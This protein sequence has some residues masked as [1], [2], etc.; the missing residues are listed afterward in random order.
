M[1]QRIF[2][3][4]DR[5]G[6][7]DDENHGV[8]DDAGSYNPIQRGQQNQ[9]A[10]QDAQNTIGN[11]DDVLNEPSE[12]PA[13]PG[14]QAANKEDLAQQENAGADGSNPSGA[15][16]AEEA[17]ARTRS[18][19]GYGGSKGQSST[20]Q[21]EETE[22]SSDN[23]PQKVMNFRGWIKKGRNKAITGGIITTMVGGGLFFTG[24]LIQTAEI[25]HAGQ[26]LSRSMAKGDHDSA[27]RLK[28]LFKSYRKYYRSA[29]KGTLAETRV[30]ELGSRSFEKTYSKLSDMGIEMKPDS[31]GRF[32]EVTFDRTKM[33]VKYP[34]LKNMSEAE[35]KDFVANK[36]RGISPGEITGTGN[37]FKLSMTD[38]T[39]SVSRM[40][41]D[42]TIGFLDTGKISQAMKARVAK[43]YLGKPGL[44]HP[45]EQKK[46]SLIDKAVSGVQLTEEEQKQETAREKALVETETATITAE[47]DKVKTAKEKY[48]SVLAKTLLFTALVCLVRDAADSIAAINDAEAQI[49]EARAFDVI[50][51]GSQDQ[52]GADVTLAQTA[53]L[54]HS[55]V[56][57]DG[58]D[59][60]GGKALNSLS[61]N[62][63]DTSGTD[64]D[65]DYKVAFMPNTTA[66]TFKTQVSNAVGGDTVA[67]ILCS[68]AGIVA[69]TIAGLALSFGSLVAEVG[70][71]GTLTGPIVAFWAL[72]EGI[73]FGATS[74]VIGYIEHKIIESSAAKEFAIDA[75]KGV[76]GGN[77]LAYG[78]RYGANQVAMASGGVSLGNN[79]STLNVA[80]AEQEDRMDFQQKSVFARVFDINDYQSLTGQMADAISPSM[81][82]NLSNLSRNALDIPGMF[83]SIFG[84][85]LPKAHAAPAPYDWGFPQI[86][87]PESLLNDPNL[88]DGF[89]NAA[90]MG[91]ILDGPAGQGLR[92]KAK[93][94]FG[95]TISKAA[96]GKW[97]AIPGTRINPN[98]EAYINAHCD[99]LSDPNWKRTII[100]TTDIADMKTV[101]CYEGND[102]SCKDITGESSINGGSATSSPTGP[103]ADAFA[104]SD[105]MTCSVGT[106]GGVQ[107][108]YHNGNLIKI[109]ICIVQGIQ[110]NARIASNVD[111]L[112]N[113]AKSQG[114]PMSGGGFRT[115]AGQIDARKRNNCPD[116][117]LSPASSCSPPTALPGYSNHQMGLAID[118][119]QNGGIISSSSSGFS[120]L[121]ANASKYGLQNLPSEPWHWSVDGN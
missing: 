63:Q 42:D 33:E 72:K 59:M 11:I 104:P 90:Q 9:A 97:D 3:Q 121:K 20:D 14:S 2:K 56:D 117:N 112:L 16:T 67:A 35:F 17:A 75:F 102:Q 81:S 26:I 12:P 64:I 4:P 109:R 83:G 93:A 76:G 71:A 37:K 38:R 28:D 48:G 89:D 110:V 80:D 23:G 79:T 95:S 51:T 94:C 47:T 69:Q 111:S 68:P 29:K 78:A 58:K 24:P 8:Y 36:I 18:A 107:D 86:G 60:W 19:E 15:S 61:T 55:F 34:E 113:D 98:S 25:I 105:T 87:I 65:P 53:A 103:V 66:N 96:D 92:D 116:I 77:L 57:K 88:E 39:F 114:V 115:M 45:I 7:R 40:M 118:F 120:W 119:T 50:A 85:L 100:F 52:K 49:A 99:D 91:P 73:Q 30:G 5:S 41:I 70:S 27:T 82:T 108:G 62:D 74:L 31:L 106:D 22:S 1:A 54:S 101:D 10:S 21:S 84:S 43:V 46:Q 32:T 44:F 6:R 13:S